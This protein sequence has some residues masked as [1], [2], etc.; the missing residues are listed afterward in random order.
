[1]TTTD[2]KKVTGGNVWDPYKEAKKKNRLTQ[3]LKKHSIIVSIISGVIGVA[4]LV[5]YITYTIKTMSIAEDM[6]VEGDT[7]IYTPTPL[8]YFGVKYLGGLFLAV[9]V[10]ILLSRRWV[11]D[12][13]RITIYLIVFANFFASNVNFVDISVRMDQK[14]EV[15]QILTD[16]ISNTVKTD[17]TF[18]D[19][20]STS[21]PAKYTVYSDGNSQ[22][23]KIAVERSSDGD[24]MYSLI[25]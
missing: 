9:T 5:F 25:K 20:F 21:I 15:R 2:G 24:F 1:M 4:I 7:M 3:F 6:K 19:D 22:K 17:V 14:A 11:I 13:V 8:A 23:M 18:S 12:N 16:W 10:V